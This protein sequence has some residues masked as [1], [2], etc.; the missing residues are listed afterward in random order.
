MN[1]HLIIGTTRRSIQRYQNW[2]ELLVSIA[3]K[4]YPARVILRDGT[5]FEATGVYPWLVE[6][7]FFNHVYTPVHLQVETNDIVVDI[8]AHIG[9]FTVFAAS[10]TQNTVYA[11]EPFPSNFEAL[12][13]NIDVNRLNNVIP[14]RVAVSDR[15]GS[16]ALLLSHKASTRHRLS[17]HTILDK[18]EK[19]Q[20]SVQHLQYKNTLLGK[21][22]EYMVV[23][24]TTLQDIMDSNNIEQ[25][26]FLKM[27]CEGSEGV[28]LASTPKNY[29]KRIRK[30]AIEF[31]DDRSKINHDDI[32]KLLEERGFTTDVK[33]DGKSLLGYLYGWR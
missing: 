32:Q 24:T 15:V 23:S 28:I 17:D 6:E 22:E 12:K 10:R 14:Y 19:S 11:F 4:Q 3:K 33:W 18:L 5:R 13:R 30:I 25:I 27:D 20:T 21:P 8:G 16:A 26:G 9:V 7:I 29:L 31:H 1:P 2:A